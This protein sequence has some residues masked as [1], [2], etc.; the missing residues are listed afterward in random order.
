MERIEEPP[1]TFYLDGCIL[2]YVFLNRQKIINKNVK[3]SYNAKFFR[4]FEVHYF[5]GPKFYFG[6]FAKLS[7]L[8]QIFFYIIIPKLFPKLC[9]FFQSSSKYFK[10][11][12]FF[13]QIQVFNHS[14]THFVFVFV[15]IWGLLFV[16]GK[17]NASCLGNFF[18]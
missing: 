3:N 5:W 16:V 11:L 1:R 15:C 4:L 18:K 9:N 7:F 17:C 8:G 14:F 6:S 13:L 12:K 10:F 2:Y